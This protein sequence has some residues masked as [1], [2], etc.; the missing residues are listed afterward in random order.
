VGH[1]LGAG[2]IAQ[3]VLDHP[4]IAAGIVFLD[5]DGLQLS[6]PGGAIMR[7]FPALYLTA[8]YDTVIRSGFVLR[9]IYEA[10]CGPDCPPFTNR[11]LNDIQRPLETAGAQQALLAFA[12]HP[13]V[14]VTSR[15]LARIKRFHIPSLV[16]FGEK[17]AE[18]SKQAAFE[19]AARLGAQPPTIIRNAGHLSMWSHPHQVALAIAMFLNWLK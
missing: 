19:T 18:F 7:V 8:L 3:F 16:V 12:Q 9:S 5:G 14:G 1:S 2:V 4:L 6:Y 10:A 11:V 13:I 17:D 15:K